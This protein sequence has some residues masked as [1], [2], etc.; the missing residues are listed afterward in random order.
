MKAAS[1]LT[2]DLELFG[3]LSAT[4]KGHCTDAAI[5]AGLSGLHPRS[6]QPEETWACMPRLEKNGTLEIAGRQINFS[7]EKNIRWLGWFIDDKPLPHPNTMRFR[8]R[9]GD[10]NHI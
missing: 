5:C 10:E 2:I 1:D 8:L 4:G 9:K 3:S 6:A 7:P